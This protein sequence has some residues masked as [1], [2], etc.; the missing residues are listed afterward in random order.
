M[1]LYYKGLKMKINVYPHLKADLATMAN[2]R[3][4][5]IHDI[6]IMILSNAALVERHI[7]DEDSKIIMA[8]Y[9]KYLVKKGH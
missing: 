1:K 2:K 3:G 8:I 4:M 5:S 7:S 9:V 6:I